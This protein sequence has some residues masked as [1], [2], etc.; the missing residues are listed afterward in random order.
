MLCPACYTTRVEFVAWM[1]FWNF[2]LRRRYIYIG[3]ET[4]PALL[5]TDSRNVSYREVRRDISQS[6]LYLQATGVYF[7]IS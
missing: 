4:Q 5:R 2:L 7:Y 1:D 6:L 3:S